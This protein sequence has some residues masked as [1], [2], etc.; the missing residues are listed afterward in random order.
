MTTLARLRD[1]AALEA[2]MAALRA[3]EEPDR[4]DFHRGALDALRWLT[5]GGPGP[6][7]GTAGGLPV[8][9]HAVV[10]ELAAAEDLI[11]G[12]PSKCRDY[13]CGLEHALMWAQFATAAPPLPA[14]REATGPRPMSVPL[15]RPPMRIART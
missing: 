9:V 13:A 2:Q 11:Y 6:L 7:T 10:R 4:R 5:D 14:R 3:L 8:T 15:P 12:R 1:R